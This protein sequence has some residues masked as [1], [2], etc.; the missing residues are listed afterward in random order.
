M[1]LVSTFYVVRY[2]IARET[3][4]CMALL[5][6]YT[7]LY[8]GM[9]WENMAAHIYHMYM[10]LCAQCVHTAVYNASQGISCA[11]SDACVVD[12]VWFNNAR[13]AVYV[14]H[15]MYIATRIGQLYV[16]V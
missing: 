16:Y 5:S 1:N 12:S 9:T 3:S 6:C 11:C 14:S 10:S 13:H 2:N 8:V 4:H 15:L 7:H